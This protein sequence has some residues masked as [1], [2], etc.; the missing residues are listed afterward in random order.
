MDGI[1]QSVGEDGSEVYIRKR[2]LF[3]KLDGVFELDALFPDFG[4]IGGKDHI[5]NLIFTELHPGG[6]IGQSH[7]FFYVLFGFF[8]FLLINE[9]RDACEKMSHVMA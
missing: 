9:G 5:D 7:D 8:G 6:L 3:R 2:E 4:F 1:F